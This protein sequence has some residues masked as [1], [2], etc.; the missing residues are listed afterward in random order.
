MI[1]LASVGPVDPTLGDDEVTATDPIL[2]NWAEPFD[3]DGSDVAVT[4]E[5]T[6]DGVVVGTEEELSSGYGAGDEVVCSVYG[7]DGTDQGD[8]ASDSII[9]KNTLPTIDSAY[10]TPNPGY[11]G[12]P[13]TCEWDGYEDIDD[14]VFDYAPDSRLLHYEQTEHLSLA[15]ACLI[16]GPQK[17]GTQ[18]T[19]AGG[20]GVG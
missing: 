9:I 12:T 19:P 15:G 16:Q 5:W 2:C 1:S 13:L 14:D 6:I 7:H 18:A 20:V 4:I 10:I 8:P 17:P 3:A 11:A